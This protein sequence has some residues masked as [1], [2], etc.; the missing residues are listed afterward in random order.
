MHDLYESNYNIYNHLRPT[1]N[2]PLASVAMHPAEDFTDGSGLSAAVK[3]YIDN[4]IGGYTKLN[5][6]EY[7]ELPSDIATIIVEQCQAASKSKG[8]AM[9]AVEKGLKE[10]GS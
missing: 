5:L 8:K 4:D 1:I 10:L 6:A 2:R 7:L 3:V 9:D